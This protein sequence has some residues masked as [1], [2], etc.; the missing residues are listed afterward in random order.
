MTAIWFLAEWALRSSILI[1]SGAALLRALRV[2]DSSIRLAAWTAMLFGSLAIPALTVSLP[3]MPLIVPHATER[4]A[5]APSRTYDAPPNLPSAQVTSVAKRS[6]ALPRRFDWPS[7]ALAIYML[8]AAALLLRVCVGL[9]MSRRLRRGSHATGQ[10]AKGVEIRES[11]RVAAPITLGIVRP[12]IVLPGDWRQWS[13]AK[14]GAVLAHEFSHIRRFDPAVQMLSA[15]HRALLWYSPLSWFL[16]SRIV[17]VA[18]EAS[19]DAALTVT[20]DRATYAEILL[21]FMQRGV[22]T[23][24]WLGVP[25]ARYGRP[26]DRIHR[27]LDGTSLSLGVTRWS[28]AAILAIGSPLAYVTAAAHP[29]IAPQAQ[30]TA[31]LAPPVQRNEAPR[32]AL[33]S[34]LPPQPRQNTAKPQAASG[35]LRGIGNV[36]PS[37]TVVV[38]PRVDGQLMSVSFKEGEMVQAGHVL[39]SIDPQPYELQLAQAQGPLMQ[40]QA[41]LDNARANLLRY[42]R[43]ALQKV[44]GE[45]Q[46][47][48]QKAAIAKLEAKIKEDQIEIDRAKLQL[49]YAHVTAPITGVAGLRLVDPGNIVHAA[50]AIVIITQLQPIA[51]LFTIPEDSLP[52]VL[53]QLRLGANVRAEAWNRDNSKKLATGRLIAVDNQIDAETGMAKLKAVFDNKDAALF[54][55][56]FVNVRLFLNSQ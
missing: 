52:Q 16:H 33:D 53:A 23:A 47:S 3:N 49:S 40:D 18:E 24:N 46:V 28:V 14:L 21:D 44:L 50:D 4:A 12:V 27:I 17:C 38:K 15:I 10:S 32:P 11:V 36:A 51:V 5:Q 34:P 42:Q 48:E 54:P 7:A 55:N 29:Q 43:L 13:A 2:K 19:D 45:E 37:A 30:A 39:A 1:L 20:R 41:A 8:G 6:P 25:M 56:Q 9:A 31:A 26:D 35:E 22:R